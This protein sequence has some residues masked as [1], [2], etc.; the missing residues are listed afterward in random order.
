MTV[1]KVYAEGKN[2]KGKDFKEIETEQEFIKLFKRERKIKSEFHG[3][4]DFYN[5]IKGV[6][7]EGSRLNS[8]SDE[9]QIV[10]IIN[11]FIERNFGGISYDIDIDFNLIFDDIKNEMTKLKDE[12]LK[13]KLMEIQEKNKKRREEEEE[14]DD[15][16][17]KRKKE[18]G[19][20]R[21]K[22]MV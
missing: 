11:T 1:L 15:E 7:I 12:I 19:K 22:E 20:K 21:K 16:D 4:R 14:E 17:D 8:I 3:N 6:S 5:I 9:K 13:G 10:P 2:L 18:E